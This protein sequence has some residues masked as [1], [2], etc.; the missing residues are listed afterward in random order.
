MHDTQI[1]QQKHTIR[2]E[3]NSESTDFKWYDYDIRLIRL[4]ARYNNKTLSDKDC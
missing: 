4:K 2:N 1:E 3:W